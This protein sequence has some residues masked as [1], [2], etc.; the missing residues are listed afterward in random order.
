ML[1]TIRNWLRKLAKPEPRTEPT[2]SRYYLLFQLH[3]NV[4]ALDA[5]HLM[6]SR[7]YPTAIRFQEREFVLC[8]HEGN[9][10]FWDDVRDDTQRTVG[11]VFHPSDNQEFIQARLWT[12]SENALIDSI[13]EVTCLLKP[14]KDYVIGCD[15]GFGGILYQEA[16][17]PRECVWLMLDWSENPIAFQLLDIPCE[18]ATS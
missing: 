14:C 9:T 13:G 7:D 17:E 3:G 2:P 6:T 18:I 16:T 12:D 15:Q 11:Y 10:V 8:H 4:C 5:T 1:S